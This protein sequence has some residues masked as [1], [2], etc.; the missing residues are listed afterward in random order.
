MTGDL[1]FYALLVLIAVSIG[2]AIV[3][4]HRAARAE[5]QA[6]LSLEAALTAIRVAVGSK[7]Q[8]V[9]E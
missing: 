5:A 7:R 9:G 6:R 4:E 8:E 1:T 2:F 3:A